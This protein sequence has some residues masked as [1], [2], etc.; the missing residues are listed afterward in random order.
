MP[1]D[2][3]NLPTYENAKYR[4]LKRNWNFVS[5]MWEGRSAWYRLDSDTFDPVKADKYL[6]IETDEPEEEYRKRLRR[7]YFKRFFRDAIE[8]YSSFLSSFI[9]EAGLDGR[10]VACLDDVDLKGNSLEVFLRKADELALRDEH[11]FILVEF[12]QGRKVRSYRE[13]MELGLRPYLCLIEATDAINWRFSTGTPSKLMQVTI[14]ENVCVEVGLFGEQEICQYRVL[15]PGKYQLYQGNSDNDIQLVEEGSYSI[16]EIPLI[17][18]SL[19]T[20]D[21]DPFGGNPPLLDLAE[22]NLEHYQKTSDRDQILHKC[23]L[24]LLEIN[25]KQQSPPLRRDKAAQKEYE[26]TYGPNTCLWNVSARFVEPTGSSIEQAQKDI[27]KLEASM[28]HRTLAFLSGVHSHMTA[29]EAGLRSVPAQGNL[30]AMARNKASNVQRCFQ[31]WLSYYQPFQ[32]IDRIESP[33][34]QVDEK[35]LSEGMPSDRANLLLSLKQSGDLSSV[36][37][38]ELLRSGKI[39]PADFEIRGSQPIIESD[40]RNTTVDEVDEVDDVEPQETEDI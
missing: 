25:E 8:L 24:P 3:F 21:A 32:P 1:Q 4:A 35:I 9:P 28:Q 17:P 36:E 34:I 13:E 22:A 30:A 37:L 12:P 29:T 38:L 7:S 39:L 31:F 5:D 16:Q 10:I 20:N 11:C 15:Q 6:P 2:L 14:R 18:Y 33:S 26:L 19:T 27:E 23:N 40:D